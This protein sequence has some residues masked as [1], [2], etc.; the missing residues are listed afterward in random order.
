MEIERDDDYGASET[1]GSSFAD[2]MKVCCKKFVF[3][4]ITCSLIGVLVF[5][6]LL[7]STTS[8][9]TAVRGGDYASVAD[10]ADAIADVQDQIADLVPTIPDTTTDDTSVAD[11]TQ[12]SDSTSSTTTPD[13]S[14]TTPSTDPSATTGTSTDPAASAGTQTASAWV[15]TIAESKLS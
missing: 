13:A 2:S 6:V 14:T 12:V 4:I 1:K 9:V 3:A 8:E 5:Q 10:I 11:Q 7:I 15:T